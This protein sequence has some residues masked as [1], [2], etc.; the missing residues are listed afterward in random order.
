MKSIEAMVKEL[1]TTTRLSAQ[2]AAGALNSILAKGGRMC[3]IEMAYAKY[4]YSGIIEYNNILEL[5]NN[6]MNMEVLKDADRT[7]GRRK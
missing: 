3:E 2:E 6:A 5:Q 7:M 4:G 1:A